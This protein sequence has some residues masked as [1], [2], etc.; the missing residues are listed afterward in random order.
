[1]LVPV[2]D[3]VYVVAPERLP[4]ESQVDDRLEGR[5]LLAH[6]HRQELVMQDRDPHSVIAGR[7]AARFP[8]VLKQSPECGDLRT[9]D[10]G[11]VVA[12][13]SVELLQSFV[14]CGPQRCEG[15]VPFGRGPSAA[16]VDQSAAVV[17]RA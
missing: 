8:E 9:R 15:G 14:L 7:P 11:Y 1:M 16:E 10:T 13:Q 6:R 12:A 4:Y 5:A 3:E 17:A 2:E